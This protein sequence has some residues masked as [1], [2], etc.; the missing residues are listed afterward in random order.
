MENQLAS[1]SPVVQG[2]MESLASR[3]L[4]F[5]GTTGGR[6]RALELEPHGM[7]M[8]LGAA[9]TGADGKAAGKRGP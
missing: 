2:S 3:E 6:A 5:F 4:R 9:A 8:A 7:G 1:L